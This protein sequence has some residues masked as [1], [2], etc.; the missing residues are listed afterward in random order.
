MGNVKFGAFESPNASVSAYQA[1]DARYGKRLSLARTYW[2]LDASFPAIQQLVTDGRTPIVSFDLHHWKPEFEKYTKEQWLI[3]IAMGLHDDILT[4]LGQGLASLGAPAFATL[5]HEPDLD[6]VQY[7]RDQWLAAYKRFYDV[8]HP[9]APNTR[10]GPI[11]T[12]WFWKDEYGQ[13]KF[14]NR[15]Q[16]I[17]V[18]PYC[19]PAHWQTPEQVLASAIPPISDRWPRKDI[20]ICETGCHEDPRKPAW[21]RALPSAVA[22]YKKIKG[23]SYFDVD[24]END[25]RMNSSI[26]SSIAAQEM[27][28]SPVWA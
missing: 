10:L 26:A 1:A 4:R 6:S 20:L 7:S 25:W 8:V 23:V 3:E 27:L 19:W 24:K 28:R 2:D 12:G 9:L 17:G 11:F 18:D 22:A 5:A 14:D 16:F 21:L 13:L 15:V